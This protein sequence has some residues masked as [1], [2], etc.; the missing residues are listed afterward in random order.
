M[1]LVLGL[2]KFFRSFFLFNKFIIS[3]ESRG[4]TIQELV[5]PGPPSRTQLVRTPAA[6]LVLAHQ[7]QDVHALSAPDETESV[8]DQLRTFS[9]ALSAAQI[10]IQ[11]RNQNQNHM[12]G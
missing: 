5:K 4:T 6:C 8:A 10:Q 3:T 2:D 1:D 11:T 7:N 9:R 12:S